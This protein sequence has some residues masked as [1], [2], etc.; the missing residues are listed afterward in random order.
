MVGVWRVKGLASFGLARRLA[1][2]TRLGVG[3]EKGVGGCGGKDMSFPQL[4][5]SS[6]SIMFWTAS[7]LVTYPLIMTLVLHPPDLAHS[8]SSK[9]NISR[10]TFAILAVTFPA[11]SPRSYSSRVIPFLYTLSPDPQ[12]ADW[13]PSFPIAPPCRQSPD[14]PVWK[15]TELHVQILYGYSHQRNM[16]RPRSRHMRGKVN[17]E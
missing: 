10:L 2:R 4:H 5:R 16:D 14:R 8:G 3:I 7:V 15:R 13:R 1:P 6:F 9:N 12:R 11:G 17:P